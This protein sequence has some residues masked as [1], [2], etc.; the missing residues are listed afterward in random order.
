MTAADQ[1][2][3]PRRLWG[4]LATLVLVLAWLPSANAQKSTSDEPRFESIRIGF[5][6]KYKVGHWT[7]VELTVR[8]GREPVVALIT[9]TTLDGDG[10]SSLVQ[11][12]RPYQIL[13][14]RVTTVRMFVRPGRSDTDFVARLMR[15]PIESDDELASKRFATRFDADESHPAV[16][17]SAT[18]ELI[19]TVGSSLGVESAISQRNLQQPPDFETWSVTLADIAQLPTRWY[20]YEGVNTVVLGGA[21]PELYSALTPTNPQLSALQH[22]VRMGGRLVLS[23]GSRADELIGENAPLADF[24]PGSY[25]GLVPYRPGR[26]FE[27]YTSATEP[28]PELRSRGGAEGRLNIPRIVNPTGRVEVREGDEL[29]LVIRSPYGFGEVLFVAVELDQAPFQRWNQRGRLVGRLLGFPQ[30]PLETGSV[31]IGQL[32]FNDL[33]GQLRAAL[34]QFN[35]VTVAPFSLV[36]VLILGYLALIG[37]VDYLLVKR[38]FK[39]LEM[40][41]ITFPT[42]VALVTVGAYAMAFQMKGKS[43]L[44]N[45]VEV[46]DVDLAGPDAEAPLV[47]G[48]NWMNVF[49]PQMRSYDATIEPSMPGALSIQSPQILMSWLGL[50]GTGFGG[51]NQRTADPPL[52]SRAYWFSPDLSAMYRVPIRVWSSKG[53]AS[54]WSAELRE[55]RDAIECD[56]QARFGDAIEGS[57]RSRLPFALEDC[58]LAYRGGAYRIGQLEPDDGFEVDE[59]SQRR[60]ALELNDRRR[61]GQTGTTTA[62]WDATSLDLATIVERMMFFKAGGGEDSVRLAN[63]YQAFMD[64]SSH[65]TMDQAVLVGRAA[66]PVSPLRLNGE[67]I[68]NP[69]NNYVTYFRFLLPVRPRT[70]AVR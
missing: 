45:Q 40:T 59:T 47:R 61:T 12:E 62:A 51:M 3:V 35:G 34:D 57:V 8:G 39:R 41:W 23:V 52:F 9:L 55:G 17:L 53:F 2:N 70:G 20:G 11:S 36:A 31:Q 42:M 1:H 13:P 29:P 33:S 14:G 7:P 64:L 4:K 48:T 21:Q 16:G 26:A 69:N 66:Q 24:V 67:T 49:S 38:F 60:L 28:L 18:A 43:M 19:V 44:V 63:S 22:W 10:I 25:A 32:G 54:R 27:T 6:N 65:L 46:I 68:D 37:P 58:L 5:N 15:A 56:L 30:N 50:P